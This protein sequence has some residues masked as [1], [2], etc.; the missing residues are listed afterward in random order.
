MRQEGKHMTF[1]KDQGRDSSKKK[2]IQWC[3][4]LWKPG[5]RRNPWTEKYPLG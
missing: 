2:N 4:M 1:T 3:H 5:K